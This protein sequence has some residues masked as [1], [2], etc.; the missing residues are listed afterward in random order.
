MLPVDRSG[1]P[2]AATKRELR[3]RR[4]RW[5]APPHQGERRLSWLVRPPPRALG[6]APA[7]C[8]GWLAWSWDGTRSSSA[9]RFRSS[10]I[11]T[12]LP[13]SRWSYEHSTKTRE[14]TLQFLPLLPREGVGGN[15]GGK[16]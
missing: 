9:R 6:S 10:L 12:F 5:G 11:Y 8:A 13:I 3:A 2:P 15:V 7:G 14:Y 4:W 1:V 16:Y